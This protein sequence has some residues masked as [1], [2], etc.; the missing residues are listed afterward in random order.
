MIT[1]KTLP[2]ATAQEVYNQVRD[3][4]RKQGKRAFNDDPDV[5]VCVYRMGDLKCAAGCLIGDDEYT[6]DMECNGWSQLVKERVVPGIH[7]NLIVAL[8]CVHDDYEPADWPSTLERVALQYD[9]TP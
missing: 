2:K 3:H 9:L 4:L 7:S 8:Q 6:A 1:L 5:R